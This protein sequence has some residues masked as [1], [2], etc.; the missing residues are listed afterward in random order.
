MSA[1]QRMKWKE[2]M[3]FMFQDAVDSNFNVQHFSGII[4]QTST[5]LFRTKSMFKGLTGLLEHFQMLAETR[6][7]KVV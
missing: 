5:Q 2:A 6:N 4:K 1:K 7:R 3:E